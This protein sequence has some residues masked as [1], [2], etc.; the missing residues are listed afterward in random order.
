MLAAILRKDPK[1]LIVLL[2]GNYS[3][4]NILL[5]QR[6]EHSMPDV[7]SRI[8]FLARMP[9]AFFLALLKQADAVIDPLHFGGGN[10]S[11]EA[12]SMGVPIVTLP[13]EFMRGRVTYACYKKM[14]MDDLIAHTAEEYVDMAVR[15]ASDKIWQSHMRE[16]VRALS[17]VLYED[18]G[19]IEE[20]ASFFEQAHQAA[21]TKN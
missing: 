21:S 4:W 19:A 14:G 12:F 9:K 17:P 13:G 5:K 20:M 1:G 7:A 11:Y 16:K 2:D 8:I 18:H 15:L 3:H 6:F 10:T